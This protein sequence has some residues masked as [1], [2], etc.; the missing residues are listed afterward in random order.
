MSAHNGVMHVSSFIWRMTPTS[1]A[2]AHNGKC[3]KREGCD[4]IWLEDL[5]L[6][7]YQI[8]YGIADNI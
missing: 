4:T 3:D 8:C 1:D 5:Y 7:V 6:Y 2:Q